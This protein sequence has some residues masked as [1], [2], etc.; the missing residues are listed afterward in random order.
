M[1]T[2]GEREPD[3]LW[4]I[5]RKR[6]REWEIRVVTAHAWVVVGWTHTHADARRIARALANSYG[7]RVDVWRLSANRCTDRFPEESSA[8]PDEEGG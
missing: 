4:A 7:D 5:A 1:S 6:P 8:R 3:E 2:P